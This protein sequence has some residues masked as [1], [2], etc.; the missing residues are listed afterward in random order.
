M[1]LM[2]RGLKTK[3]LANGLQSGLFSVL[4]KHI[5]DKIKDS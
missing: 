5:D 3:I 2:T 1:G 4:W